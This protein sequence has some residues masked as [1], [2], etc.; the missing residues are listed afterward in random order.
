MS[1]DEDGDDTPEDAPEDELDAE[2]DEDLDL[3]DAGENGAGTAFGEEDAEGKGEP[4][5]STDN[6]GD[7]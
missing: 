2:E 5:V 4:S 7:K 6:G 1:I 3:V